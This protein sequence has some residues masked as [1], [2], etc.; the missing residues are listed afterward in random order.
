MFKTRRG[1]ISNFILISYFQLRISYFARYSEYMRTIMII[2]SLALLASCVPAAPIKQNPP[3]AQN[4]VL[5]NPTDDP[6]DLTFTASGALTHVPVQM[7]SVGTILLGSPDAP[8]TLTETFDYTCEYCREV[9]LKHW[10]LL[11]DRYIKTGKMNMILTFYPLSATGESAARA[12]ICAQSQEKFIPMHLALTSEYTFDAKTLATIAKELGLDVPEWQKCLKSEFA[13]GILDTH[14]K[15]IEA[16]GI[17]RVPHFSLQDE[18]WE[19]VIS[20]SELVGR[21]EKAMMSTS[22]SL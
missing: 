21:I 4:P 12:A 2:C 22:S 13:N 9:T 6:L 11:A 20:V 1:I 17:E 8:V 3:S 5:T 16:K 14:A 15:L 7:L 10:P 19:G 18:T